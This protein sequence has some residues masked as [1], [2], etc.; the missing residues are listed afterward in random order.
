MITPLYSAS[1]SA[2][3]MLT[4]M[5]AKGLPG[6]R[7]NAADPGYTATDLNG[8]SGPQTVTEGTDAIVELATLDADGPT[9]TYRDRHGVAPF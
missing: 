6:I 3:T 5:Y 4:T 7:V 2:V 9:G 1:K 8:H